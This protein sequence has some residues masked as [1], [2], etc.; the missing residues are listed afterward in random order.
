MIIRVIWTAVLAAVAFVTAQL[1]F[2]RQVL[3]DPEIASWVI[4][5]LRGNAQVETVV[6]ALGGNYPRV[7]MKEARVLVRRRPVPAENLTLLAQAYFKAGAPEKAAIT[8]QIA[9]QRGWR[10]PIAQESIALLAIEA[11]D[12][13]EAS[14]RFTAMMVLGVLSDDKMNALAQEIFVADDRAGYDTLIEIVGGTDRWGRLFLDRGP[15]VMPPASFA[16][17]I[18]SATRQGVRFDCARLK[19]SRRT[20]ERRDP[21][22]GS[23]LMAV[24]PAHCP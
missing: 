18:V 8:V 5:P 19:H 6:A 17:T 9:A 7:A 15:K 20:I 13:A 1:Q 12:L 11:G 14:R 3:R 24:E 21:A 2:D 16:E 10:E 22:A 23:A 4:P